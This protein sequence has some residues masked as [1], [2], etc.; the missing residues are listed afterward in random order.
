[1]MLS[2]ARTT[3]SSSQ[4]H[5][6]ARS[7]E[8]TPPTASALSTSFEALTPHTLSYSCRPRL[9]TRSSALSP[10]RRHEISQPLTSPAL[11]LCLTTVESATDIGGYRAV[12][13]LDRILG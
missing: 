2:V 3:P 5:M 13:I 8:M 6:I 4:T 10:A 7:A 9:E 1:M 11:R 12:N